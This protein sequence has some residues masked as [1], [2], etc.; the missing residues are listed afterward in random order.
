MVLTLKR[1]K[2]RSSPGIIAGGRAGNPFTSQRA[3]PSGAALLAFS[4]AAHGAAGWSSPVAR[5]AHNLKVVGSNPTP[6]TTTQL[7]PSTIASLFQRGFCAFA[8]RVE[9]GQLVVASG[10]RPS[11]KFRWR[12]ISSSILQKRH[13]Q[14]DACVVGTHSAR[15]LALSRGVAPQGSRSLR[16]WQAKHSSCGARGR[17]LR[18]ACLRSQL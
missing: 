14:R 5:Q 10:H 7:G 16:S 8:S 6:A 15:N 11:G 18:D 9:S 17:S 4:N 12:S 13:G 3:D 1:W 2:S